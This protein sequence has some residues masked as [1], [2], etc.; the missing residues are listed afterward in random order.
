MAIVGTYIPDPSNRTD[1]ARREF[2]FI[3]GPSNRSFNTSI[4]QYRGS[5]NKSLLNN[6]VIEDADFTYTDFNS[7]NKRNKR[8]AVK[9]TIRGYTDIQRNQ[10]ISSDAFKYKSAVADL[11]VQH[12]KD[13]PLG[14]TRKIFGTK[15]GDRTTA[16]GVFRQKSYTESIYPGRGI[17]GNYTGEWG[18]SRK[19]A[20]AATSDQLFKRAG[21]FATGGSGYKREALANSFG[22][23]TKRQAIK[24]GLQSKLIPGIALLSMY[25]AYKNGDNVTETIASNAA[26]WFG[27]SVGFRVG[28]SFG[29][30]L[31]RSAGMTG[32]RLGAVGFGAGLG[33]AAIGTVG[34][35]VGVAAAFGSTK[36]NNM[37]NRAVDNLRFAAINNDFVQTDLSLTHRQRAL[38]QISKAALN[39]RG[40]ILGN[41]ASV[42]AGM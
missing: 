23:I 4:A 10:F 35:A 11:T 9:E 33:L 31:A 20:N 2:E 39:N 24:G 40:Q 12:Y 34:L 30:G 22:I 38:E 36:S 7:L 15:T 25:G 17:N 16:S 5:R 18:L 3:K 28:Q 6:S 14:G 8:K 42:L 27:G 1:I 13:I 37:L 41:E 26:T 32:L 29:M 21:I 19:A